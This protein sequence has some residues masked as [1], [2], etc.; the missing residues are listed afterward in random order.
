VPIGNRSSSTWTAHRSRQS[1]QPISYEG[2]AASKTGNSTL[3][4][5]H[6]IDQSRLRRA[7]AEHRFALLCVGSV[8]LHDPRTLNLTSPPCIGPQTC[9]EHSFD[10]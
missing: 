3:R 6:N 8:T 10:A 5:D 7:T 4:Q 1:N 9:T 2:Y